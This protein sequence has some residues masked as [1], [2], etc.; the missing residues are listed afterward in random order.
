M[1]KIWLQIEQMDENGEPDSEPVDPIDVGEFHDL[2]DAEEFIDRVLRMGDEPP[3]E[4]VSRD[5]R[6][7]CP[8]LPQPTPGPAHSKLDE[9]DSTEDHAEETRA[10]PRP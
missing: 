6:G 1:F 7:S 3:V 10:R 9:Q 2:D 4:A 8:T 5:A